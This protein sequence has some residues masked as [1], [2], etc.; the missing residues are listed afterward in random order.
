VKAGIIEKIQKCFKLSECEGATEAE[1][2]TALRMAK[3]LMA[4]NNLSMADVEAATSEEKRAETWTYGKDDVSAPKR[5]IDSWEKTLIHAINKLCSVKG[6]LWGCGYDGRKQ[7]T[8]IVYVG[9]ERDAA[10]AVALHRELCKTIKVCCRTALG[11]VGKPSIFRRFA[12]GFVRSVVER[13]TEERTEGL[14]RDEEQTYALVVRGKKDWLSTQIEKLH[15]RTGRA[16][17]KVRAFNEYAYAQGR[18]AGRSADLGANRL[19]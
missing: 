18:A 3:K 5:R 7:L 16:H 14:T 13:V 4:Q 1:A 11:R 17:G 15:L 2:A 6:I 10:I 9:D 12:E 8:K 19:S